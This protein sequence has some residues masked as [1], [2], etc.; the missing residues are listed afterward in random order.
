LHTVTR[1]VVGVFVPFSCAASIVVLL[2]AAMIELNF[3]IVDWNLWTEL[4]NVSVETPNGNTSACRGAGL[5]RI[6]TPPKSNLL[7][8]H[9]C[10]NPFFCLKPSITIDVVFKYKLIYGIDGNIPEIIYN[11]THK[12][13]AVLQ[14]SISNRKTISEHTRWRH[15]EKTSW[16]VLRIVFSLP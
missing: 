11:I 9:L 10:A 3:D 1:E 4:P 12:H 5:A 8:Q 16:G 15:E 7:F 6:E 13:N 14:S 2:K